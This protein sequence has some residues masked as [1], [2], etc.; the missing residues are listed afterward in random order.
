MGSLTDGWGKV[1]GAAGAEPV[2]AAVAVAATARERKIGRVSF[3][4]GR[5]SGRDVVN[6]P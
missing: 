5:S 4:R 3:M 2:A 1:R 6:A